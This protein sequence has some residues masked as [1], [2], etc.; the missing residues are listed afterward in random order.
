MKELVKIFNDFSLYKV[1]EK[2]ELLQISQLV[3]RV[4]YKHHLNQEFFPQ[5][6]L[7]KLYNF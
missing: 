7:L 5:D 1:T 4:N 6:E 3:L 2:E